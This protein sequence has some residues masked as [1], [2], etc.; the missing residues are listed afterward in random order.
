MKIM[1]SFGARGSF[2]EYYAMDFDA[3]VV[4]MVHDGPG[5]YQN[6]RGSN[7]DPSSQGL[8]RQGRLRRQRRNVGQA[9][10]CDTAVRGRMRRKDKALC[11]EGQ[12]VAGP[13]LEIGNTNSRY[14]F[15]IG[16]R[17]FV[18]NWN[19]QGPAH[20]CAVGLGHIA[21]RLEKLGK[22]LDIEFVRIC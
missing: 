5:A 10:P 17:A 12:S 8:P 21:S 19:T 14:Q 13:I 18:E 6:R 15:P 7:Q 1:D 16:A 20:H 3:D 4:L 9:W 2:T 22:L 11:A